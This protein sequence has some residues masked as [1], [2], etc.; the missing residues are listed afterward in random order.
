MDY[1][2]AH[3]HLILP[4]LF[5]EIF[6]IHFSVEVTLLTAIIII[7]FFMTRTIKVF[8]PDVTVTVVTDCNGIDAFSK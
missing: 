8:I 4:P 7:L 5:N 1:S 6:I 2:N 3:V